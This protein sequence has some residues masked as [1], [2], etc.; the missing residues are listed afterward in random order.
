M[1]DDLTELG[2]IDPKTL[3]AERL[4]LHYGALILGSTANSLLNPKEDDSHTS[5]HFLPETTQLVSRPLFGHSTVRLFLSF[6]KLKLAFIDNQNELATLGLAG[7][8]MQEAYDWATGF[9]E[10]HGPILAK[11]VVQ[12]DYADF[13]D[14]ELARGGAFARGDSDARTELA[15]YYAGATALLEELK[16]DEPAMS[17]I[18]IW[19]HHFDI[20]ALISLPAAG[21]TI[22]LGLSPGDANYDEPYFYV[23]PY[24]YPEAAR[25][26]TLD[27]P[28]RWHTTGFTAAVLPASDLVGTADQ[29][30]TVRAFLSQ[31]VRSSRAALE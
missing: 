18:V 27:G 1:S 24:P 26:A 5:L 14:S 30:S 23:S 3:K 9:A 13:P 29:A 6:P 17:E 12:R 15:R 7:V 21:K 2:S 16:G 19:P 25:L 28:G 31:A 11:Q 22:G 8:T 4:Q 20:A 10:R